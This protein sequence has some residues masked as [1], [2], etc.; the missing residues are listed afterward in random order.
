MVDNADILS[1]AS[2]TEQ[3]VIAFRRALHMCPETAFEEHETAAFIRRT[4][5]DMGLPWREAGTGTIVDIPAQGSAPLIALRADMDGLPMEEATGLPYASCH[6]G[7]MHAC[8]HDCHTAMLLG[9]AGI[10]WR[11]RQLL[12][13]PVRLIF[14]PAEESGGGASRMIQAGCLE[15]VSAIYCLHMQGGRAAG[16]FATRPDYIHAASD[17]FVIRVRGKSSHGASPNSGVDAIVIA[18]HIILALQEIVS[19]EVSAFSSVVLTIGRITGGTARNIVCGEVQLD[20][21]LRTLGED[22]RSAVRQ[23]IVEISGQTA[24]MLRGSAEVDFVQ[25]YCACRNDAALTERTVQLARELFG[26]DAVTILDH[27][28]MGGEDFGFYQ[29]QTPGVKL[30]LGTGRSESVHTSTFQVDEST[31][32]SGTALLCALAFRRSAA[33]PR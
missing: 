29:Q 5:A 24:G 14:Q 31:L 22:V 11:R 30:Y 2:Q 10:L 16:C 17:G 1:W 9:A 4:L 27:C 21:T 23:R 7:R 32:R 15:G 25:G 18:A 20:G 26:P 33:E 6:A 28:S 3:E 13:G 12:P 19:R 8:G